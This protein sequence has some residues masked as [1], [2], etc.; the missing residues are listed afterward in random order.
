MKFTK[1]LGSA[2]LANC[3]AGLMTI[4]SAQAAVTYSENTASPVSI[5][6]LTGFA[7]TG[8]MMDG[9]SV[10]ATFSNQFSETRVWADTGATSGGVTGNGWSLSLN[11][12]SFSSRWSFSFTD[13]NAA[14]NLVQLVLNGSTGLTV[15]DRTFGDTD[16]TPGSALGWDFDFTAT[17]P[18]INVTYSNPIEIGAADFVGDLWQ[19]VMADF[20]G[21]IRTDFTFG[22]DTDND[23][24]Y[25]I[26]EPGSL[27]LL[28]MGLLGLGF[29]RRRKS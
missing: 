9:M 13:P 14:L 22:H 2:L 10:T 1:T 18:D 15:F 25:S 17:S 19:M 26:P 8:A 21:G 7:T 23:S 3:V 20:D 29:S 24:R 16:G 5:P 6:G 28:G 4:G 11:G 27:A 12:D